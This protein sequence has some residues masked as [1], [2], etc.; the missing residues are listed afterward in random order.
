MKTYKERTER[1]EEKAKTLKR[2]RRKKI[3]SITS[4]ALA[5]VAAA[6]L[7]LF[8][9]YQT[10]GVDIS[11]YADSEYY[12]VIEQLSTLTYGEAT[13]TNNF[14]EWFGNLSFGGRDD[15]GGTDYAPNATGSATISGQTY[16]EMT[17]NQTAGVIESDLCKRSDQ[18]AYYLNYVT[19]ESAIVKDEN[20]NE[21]KV[22]YA[23]HYLI[24]VYSIAKEDSALVASYAVYPEEGTTFKG[25]EEEG[26]LFLST[27]CRTL[28]V[29][30]PCYDTEQKLLY[31]SLVSLDVTDVNRIA[32]QNRMYVSG[33]Y[34]SSRMTEET[35]LLVSN[36]S[37][38][39]RTD[40]SDEA[41][42]LPQ[43]GT[44]GDMT[45]LPLSDIILPDEATSASYTVVCSLDP[46]TLSVSDCEAFLSYSEEV[47]VSAENLFVTRSYSTVRTDLYEGC[48][49]TLT[50]PVTEIYRVA[51]G[52]DGDLDLKDSAV[53]TGTVNDQYSMDEYEGVL[54]VFTTGTYDSVRYQYEKE[55]YDNVTKD[56]RADYGI[57]A[58][59]YC[60]DVETM[61]L[62]ASV[63]G[64]APLGESVMSA[65]FDGDTAYVCTAVVYEVVA[66]D[67]V[68]QFDLSDYS[69]IT[70]TD[71]G[72][73]PGYSL[74]LITFTDGT[75][76]GI[77]YG[78]DLDSLKISLYREE[79]GTVVSVAEYARDYAMFSDNFKAYFIDAENGLIGLGVFY[80]QYDEETQ[81]WLN[82]SGY[83]LLRFDGYDLVTVAE[84][85]NSAS[86]T[87][88]RMRADYEDGYLYLF[89][90]YAFEAIDIGGM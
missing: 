64:F 15:D 51:Y 6:N 21:T 59:L 39:S 24:E 29:L 90:Q 81:T 35:L 54:R 12:A 74:S 18:Y 88:D 47:Y 73:I 48:T 36:F 31:T 14:D 25:Y 43:T 9:P 40:F 1:I 69:H 60:F 63:E 2:R 53:V 30:T 65:R 27:D 84:I 11:A 3:I 62:K 58:N 37:V 86:G 80:S 56:E 23:S 33:S 85:D 77:G 20:G 22:T 17:N 78:E 28:T 19:A 41:Q 7:V 89:S 66:E 13:T 52:A 87:Y 70:Y 49:V 42:F 83:L 71:T 79:D 10:G 68:F 44:R 26:E 32:E 55:G 50:Y 67:P 16:A 72:T 76:L 38:K 45:S 82:F 46:K 34:V 75:L 4:G 61:T 8:V 57:T 5:L